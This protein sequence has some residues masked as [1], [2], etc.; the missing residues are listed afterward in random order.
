M[1]TQENQ[2]GSL[3]ES[4]LEDVSYDSSTTEQIRRDC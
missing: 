4:L 3:L 2:G 1:S